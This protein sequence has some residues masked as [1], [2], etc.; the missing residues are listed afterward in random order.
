MADRT[1]TPSEANSALDQVRP[2]AERMVEVRARLTELEG[3]QREVE[4]IAAGNG[5]SAGV[6]EARTPEFAALAAEFQRCFDGLAELG[7]E[8]KDV[9]TGLLDF[10][11]VRDGEEV[12]LCWRPGEAAGRVVARRRRRASPAGSRS[13]GATSDRTTSGSRLGIAAAG[14]VARGDRGPLVDARL[15]QAR[16]SRPATMTRY[17]ILR[18]SILWS[19]V[20]V[21]DPLG[22]ARD[23][24]GARGRG[25]RSSPRPP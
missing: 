24:A 25:R 8:V 11:S 13:T 19:I 9:D 18:R 21:G 16:S 1:F 20:F 17:R 14:I 5:S 15:A 23:P 22:A 3:E 12:L 7:V 2:L 4:Q 10:P 6:G